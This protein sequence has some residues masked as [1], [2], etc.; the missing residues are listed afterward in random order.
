MVCQA[1][2]QPVETEVRFCTKCGTQV[3]GPPV[4]APPAGY[5]PPPMYVMPPMMPRVQRNLQALGVLWCIYGAYRV[6]AGLMGMFFLRA[7]SMGGF[8]YNGWHM[9]HD[10]GVF[11]MPWM[12]ALV[13]VIGTITVIGAALALLVGIGLLSRKP[14]GRTVAIVAAVLALFKPLLGTGL[15]IYTLWVLVPAASGLEYDAIADRS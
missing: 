6:I 14:W 11:G 4:A 7:M 10:F 12:G 15:G 13:P 1:C 2:G 5:S 9:H 3:S 8:G